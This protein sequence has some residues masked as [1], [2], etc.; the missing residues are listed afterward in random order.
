MQGL[1]RA[2]RTTTYGLPRPTARGLTRPLSAT[3]TWHNQN[4]RAK[5]RPT[6]SS[7]SV[8]EPESEPVVSSEPPEKIYASLPQTDLSQFSLPPARLRALIDLYHSSST[9][10]TPETLSDEID[11]AFAPVRPTL[12]NLGKSYKDLLYKRDELDAEPDRVVPSANEEDGRYVRF[13]IMD[14]AGW[15][16]SK[17]E[18]DRMVKAALWGV[19]PMA[20]IGL[21]TLLEAKAE[22]DQLGF[23]EPTSAEPVKETKPKETKTKQKK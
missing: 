18:R 23:S 9:F 14:D 11:K 10:V 3:S 19:D 17:G 5:P 22:M 2:A 7:Q 6:A 1:A 16:A 8:P 4:S 20:K 12:L 15:S 21:E 13:D